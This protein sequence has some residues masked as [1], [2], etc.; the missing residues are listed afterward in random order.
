[1][2]ITI[3]QIR[4]FNA[5]A[6][7]KSFVEACELI[8][9]SQPALSIT[10][11]NLEESVGGKLF[12]RSTRHL[13]LTPEGKKFLPTAKRLLSEWDGAMDDLNN[14]FLLNKG[15]FSIAAMPSFASSLLS[16]HL[17]EFYK[18][19]PAINIKIHDV[20]AE[21]TLDM[22]RNDKAEIAIT[23]DPGEQEDLKFEPLFTDEFV[24][25]L[26][27]NHRLLKQSSICWQ[28]IAQYPFIALQRPSSI[29]QLIDTTMNNNEIVL[30]VVFE[31]N[32]LTTVG[33][34]VATGLGISAMPSL[35]IKQLHS[36][37]VECRPLISPSISRKVGIVSKRRSPLSS[38]AKSFIFMMQQHHLNKS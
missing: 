19:H 5:V 15:S 29:R 34:M 37:G 24:V 28:D 26:P 36:F 11:K 27:H 21:D 33:Q 35:C 23:F 32:Q 12:A 10:I 17:L 9:L 3:K 18:K 4:A 2:N 6:Q 31:A 25:A 14:S 30:N 7:T 22:V 20:I 13:V 1:M 38:A 16:A 8:H